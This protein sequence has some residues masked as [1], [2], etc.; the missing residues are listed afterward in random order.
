VGAL[1]AFAGGSLGAFRLSDIGA[2]AL[3]LVVALAS[4]LVAGAL[5]AVL[6]DTWRLHTR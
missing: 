3:W 4:E 2:P 6:W 1:D 5:V